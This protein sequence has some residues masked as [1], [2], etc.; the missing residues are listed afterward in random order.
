MIALSIMTSDTA[1]VAY[2]IIAGLPLF[3]GIS[4]LFN[5]ADEMNKYWIKKQ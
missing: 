1:V 4:L 5:G 3:I 2:M